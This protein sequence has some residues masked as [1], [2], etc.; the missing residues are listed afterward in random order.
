MTPTE[1]AEES[2]GSG[3]GNGPG[4]AAA[5]TG[6][7]L[8]ATPVD[9]DATGAGVCHGAEKRKGRGSPSGRKNRPS[10]P[11][12]WEKERGGRGLQIG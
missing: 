4:C 1:T 3:M 2:E 12:E 8:D 5:V 7:T 6:A 10:S 9:A 11:T